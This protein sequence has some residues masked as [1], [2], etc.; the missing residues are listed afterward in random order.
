M[1]NGDYFIAMCFSMSC[2]DI[3]ETAYILREGDSPA[4]KKMFFLSDKSEFFVYR[5]VLRGNEKNRF[6]GF[7]FITYEQADAYFI[8]STTRQEYHK[9]QQ[10]LFFIERKI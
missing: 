4:F 6:Q 8:F 3:G 5:L 10:R 2:Q 1:N 9:I 7:S